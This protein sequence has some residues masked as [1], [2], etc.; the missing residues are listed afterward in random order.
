MYYLLGKIVFER[1]EVKD[2]IY[3]NFIFVKRVTVL[4]FNC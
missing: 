2:A 3:A 4:S 1:S